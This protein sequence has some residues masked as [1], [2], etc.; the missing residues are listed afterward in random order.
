M[1][2][3][4]FAGEVYRSAFSGGKNQGLV[5]QA[6]ELKYYLREADTIVLLLN[7]RDSITHGVGDKRAID[8]EYSALAMLKF[9]LEPDDDAQRLP[10]V[11][12]AL[13]QTDAYSATIEACGGPRETLAKYLPVV[14]SSFGYLDVVAVNSC[15]TTIDDHGDSVP[16][17]NLSLVGLKP[18][19]DW[20]LNAPTDWRN[21]W[22]ACVGCGRGALHAVSSVDW[23]GICT[24]PVTVTTLAAL[25]VGSAFVGI[26]VLTFHLEGFL[27][28]LVVYGVLLVM[29]P[30]GA[31]VAENVYRWPRWSARWILIWAAICF[32]IG[33]FF[34]AG[35]SH[36]FDV[37]FM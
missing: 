17:R 3:L 1:S 35:F 26:T 36:L 13:S 34:V 19:V 6:E 24:S 14:A 20:M 12:L 4:D 37:I 29:I 32:L 25:V 27:Q 33:T 31:G 23:R 8:T 21:G 10:R 5:A 30:C 28:H 16:D 11:L 15:G 2:C 22:R 18:M 7:L 9:V